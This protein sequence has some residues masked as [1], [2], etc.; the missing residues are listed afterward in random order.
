MKTEESS[1]GR[2]SLTKADM[3]MNSIYEKVNR[4]Q[5]LSQ[6]SNHECQLPLPKYQESGIFNAYIGPKSQQFQNA[7]TGYNGSHL[8]LQQ[9]QVMN[10][11]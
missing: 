7:S 1:G 11:K 10:E 5:N 3:A 4:L 6:L 9:P 8:P 2:I